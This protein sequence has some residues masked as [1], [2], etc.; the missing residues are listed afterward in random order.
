MRRR[1]DFPTEEQIKKAADRA[2]RL[3][4]NASG[5]TGRPSTYT[6]KV[7]EQI[8]DRIAEGESLRTICLD[9]TM[10]DR[11]TVHRWLEAY[12]AFATKY[13]RARELQGDAMDEKILAVADAC[14]P[15]T[16]AADRVKILAYQWRA[17]KLAPK[18]YGDKIEHT[19]KDGGPI[20]TKDVSARDLLAG[21]LNSIASGRREG[22]DSRKPH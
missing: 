9:D 15:E 19:G 16:A 1:A 4:R 8:C 17:A 11:R 14:T 20:E 3:E 10:P 21:K 12:P 5:K 18:K 2:E 13:A 22:G 7:A 6:A